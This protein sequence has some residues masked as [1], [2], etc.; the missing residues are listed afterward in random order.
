M[1]IVKNHIVICFTSIIYCSAIWSSQ[2]PNPP[3]PS[4]ATSLSLPALTNVTVAWK[5][6]VRGE[7]LVLTWFPL[8]HLHQRKET[9]HLTKSIE[10]G[11]YVFKISTAKLLEWSK[12]PEDKGKFVSAVN[13]ERDKL[14][15]SWTRHVHKKRLLRELD[16]LHLGFEGR[17]LNKNGLDDFL[18]QVATLYVAIDTHRAAYKKQYP[19]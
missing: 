11:T 14:G 7:S 15:N 5:D 16:G 13:S 10:Q 18:T 1:N 4:R 19:A 6:K 17:R 9:A 2:S 8:N 12:D 3:V